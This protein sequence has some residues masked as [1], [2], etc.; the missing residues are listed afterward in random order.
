MVFCSLPLI[1]QIKL[2][3][4]KDAYGSDQL[5]STI[6]FLCILDDYCFAYT[7]A[8]L[9]KNLI[10]QFRQFVTLTPVIIK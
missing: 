7:L 5:C 2:A 8:S 1:T 9:D 3:V 10:K 4:L 6:I